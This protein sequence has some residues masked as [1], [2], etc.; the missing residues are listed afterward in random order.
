MCVLQRRST[1][2]AYLN[3]LELATRP[4]E[5]I[6]SLFY[7][8]YSATLSIGKQPYIGYYKFF[9]QVVRGYPPQNN[10]CLGYGQNPHGPRYFVSQSPENCRY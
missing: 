8:A 1:L 4:F 9:H 10:I 2:R 7:G 5:V 3:P 6:G